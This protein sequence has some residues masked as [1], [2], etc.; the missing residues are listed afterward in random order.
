MIDFVIFVNKETLMDL[1]SMQNTFLRLSK[2][3]QIKAFFKGI[4]LVTNTSKHILEI[5]AKH[6]F[7]SS[8]LGLFLKVKGMNPRVLVVDPKVHLIAR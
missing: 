8:F 6:N 1:L 2:C 5:R 4:N 3:S 7:Y